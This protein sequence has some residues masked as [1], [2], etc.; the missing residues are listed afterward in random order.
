MHSMII[1]SRGVTLRQE[2]ARTFEVEKALEHLKSVDPA[3]SEVIRNTT[4][5]NPFVETPDW[6]TTPPYEHLVRFVFS[7]KFD[8]FIA[9]VCGDRKRT[10][11]YFHG[12]VPRNSRFASTL[13]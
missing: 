8:R 3:M 7:F 9:I 12:V 10:V 5:P 11:S 2:P 13:R 4:K 6:M 1:I